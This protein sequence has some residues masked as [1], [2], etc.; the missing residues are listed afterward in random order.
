MFDKVLL[1]SLFSFFPLGQVAGETYVLPIHLFTAPSNGTEAV[2]LVDSASLQKLRL[3]A[4]F[5]GTTEE[6]SVH[7]WVEDGQHVAWTPAELS[8]VFAYQSDTN[9]LPV[10]SV[11][12]VS[13]GEFV[14]EAPLLASSSQAHVSCGGRAGGSFYMEKMQPGQSWCA[15]GNGGAHEAAVGLSFRGCDFVWVEDSIAE[16]ER[17]RGELMCD[18]PVTAVRSTFVALTQHRLP[19]LRSIY[20]DEVSEVALGSH[21]D[22]VSALTA[23]G[24]FATPR[25]DMWMPSCYASGYG[26]ED[27]S[28]RSDGIPF[29]WDAAANPGCERATSCA[30]CASIADCTWCTGSTEVCSSIPWCVGGKSIGL[31][32]SCP[33]ETK[34]SP[35]PTSMPS[36]I[37]TGQPTPIPSPLPTAQP[38]QPPTPVPTSHPTPQPSKGPTIPPTTPRPTPMPSTS[39]TFLPTRNPTSQPT[40]QPHSNPSPTMGTSHAP[41]RNPTS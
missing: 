14:L 6:L 23:G 5:A 25:L 39:P 27:W 41:T 32:D 10:R 9:R 35:M 1:L 13:Y 18:V 33:E 28:V 2:P 16:T 31:A 17:Q 34:P 30:D 38:T 11:S 37:P 20:V 7:I 36:S 15:D 21:S 3:E 12:V 4:Q 22:G 26:D 8:Q 24:A 29:L 40:S 19:W